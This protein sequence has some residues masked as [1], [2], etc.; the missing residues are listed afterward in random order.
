MFL[1]IK[2]VFLFIL[3][4]KIHLLTILTKYIIFKFAFLTLQLK[5]NRKNYNNIKHTKRVF[6]SVITIFF[7]VFFVRK[8]TKIIIFLFLKIYF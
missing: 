8:N 6:G 1:F 3:H 5:Y 4:E 2:N 7:K